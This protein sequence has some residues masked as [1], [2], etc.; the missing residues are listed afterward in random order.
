MGFFGRLKRIFTRKR[1]FPL[2]LALGSGG[3]KGMAHIGVLKAFEEEGIR[4]TVI[5]GTSIGSIVGALYGKGYSADD[6]TGIVENLNRK[7][8]SRN[9]HP[10][11]DMQ[12]AEELLG[13]FLEGNIEDLPV[14]FA[15]CV[16]DAETN[17]GAVLTEGNVAR[18]L[19]A[20]SA[21]PPF[22][23]SVEIG[24]RKLYDGAFTNA[25]PAD[26]CKQLGAKFVVAVD[27]SAYAPPE[28]EKGAFARFVGSTLNRFTPV[29][30]LEDCKTRGYEAADM[31][32]RP[33]LG[34]FKATDVS[35]VSMD[36]M[37]E[38]GYAEAKAQMPELKKRLRKAGY[39]L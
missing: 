36:A 30:Y 37:F 8:F 26:V 12:F 5:A 27:L 9:L 7:E 33:R 18:A 25:V 3:A 20:S 19:C 10:F 23:K 39:A 6:M 16:T 31:M 28:E 35:R 21:I 17:E 34:G 2:G 22:F 1:A 38:A 15:C 11:A 24:G 4:F 32:L 13:R 29:R 14:P